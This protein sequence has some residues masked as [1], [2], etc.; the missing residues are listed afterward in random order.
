M[1]APPSAS[2]VA[3]S[4]AIS[5]VMGLPPACLI[6]AFPFRMAAAMV[7][8][9]FCWRT[10]SAFCSLF[11]LAPVAALLDD[12]KELSADD[13]DGADDAD[14]PALVERDGENGDMSCI[15]FAMDPSTLFF[16]R[17]GL[18][19]AFCLPAAAAAAAGADRLIALAFGG[20]AET[21]WRTSVNIVL[22]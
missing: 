13:A 21:T 10:A 6:F 19:V 5:R 11:N 20:A 9:L 1:T 3:I 17:C 14:V 2:C 16:F 22:D 15:G 4:Y 18:S 8:V 7:T 12:V